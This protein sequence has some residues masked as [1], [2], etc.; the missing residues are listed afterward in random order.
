MNCAAGLKPSA[1]DGF[2]IV[3]LG[4][5]GCVLCV[6]VIQEAG[7]AA[8]Q[9]RK[10]GSGR[11]AGVASQVL[12]QPGM[13]SCPALLRGAAG[14]EPRKLCR[15]QYKASCFSVFL[16]QIVELGPRG[17]LVQPPFDQLGFFSSD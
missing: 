2:V 13:K 10:F 15:F 12:K 1:W 6:C 14:N 17:Y 8:E 11:R 5:G 16:F 4:C 3:P 7:S 9:K